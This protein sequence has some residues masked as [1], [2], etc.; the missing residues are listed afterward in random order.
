M[1]V[2]Q[3]EFLSGQLLV[4]G[5]RPE[6]PNDF[7]AG[8][9]GQP[10][11]GVKPICEDARTNRHVRGWYVSQIVGGERSLAHGTDLPPDHPDRVDQSNKYKG[12]AGQ[13]GLTGLDHT[14]RI[15]GE[16]IDPKRPDWVPFAD[17]SAVHEQCGLKAQES[18]T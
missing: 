7:N 18:A 11:Q 2:D 1:G 10:G 14:C 4:K 17:G 9:L 13:G 5:C 6:K 12:L 16:R 3:G 15:C 8:Q